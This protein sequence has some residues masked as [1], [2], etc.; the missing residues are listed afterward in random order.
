MKN[1]LIKAAAVVLTAMLAHGAVYADFMPEADIDREKESINSSTD[2]S[3]KLI[4]VV[5]DAEGLRTIIFSGKLKDFDN[6]KWVGTAFSDADYAIIFD[7]DSPE[8]EIIYIVYPGDENTAEGGEEIN[9]ANES[10]AGNSDN[11]G[12]T[13]V[14][15]IAYDIKYTVS[16]ENMNVLY[17]VNNSAEKVQTVSM[18][19]V[20]YKNK[21]LHKVITTPLTVNP[22]TKS[23]GSIAMLLPETG[24]EECSVKMMVW[25]NTN[26]IRPLGKAKEVKDTESYLRE[27]TAVI[28]ADAGQEFNLFMSS[29]NAIGSNGNAEH[30]IRYDPQKFT[31]VDLRGLT[32]EKELAPGRIENTG[33]TVKSVDTQNGKII[34]SFDLPEGRNTGINNVVK[35][36]ALSDMSGEEIIYEIN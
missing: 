25:E 13:G 8:N 28:S 16:G 9:N 20:L 21:K 12:M 10:S 19:A 29:D 35:L 34:F 23:S 14:S 4:K 1:K 31:A 22:G 17:S 18:I 2:N 32:Y 24:R 26:T 15:G 6:G 7:W 33:I 5:K 3:N 11:Q 30:I 36:K 27:K